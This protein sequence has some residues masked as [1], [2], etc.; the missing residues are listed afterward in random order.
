MNHIILCL[1]AT[2]AILLYCVEH[3]NRAQYTFQTVGDMFDN[4]STPLPTCCKPGHQNKP[5][6]QPF[7]IWMDSSFVH[8]SD[9]FLGV[10]IHCKPTHV[11]VSPHRKHCL[12]S[13]RFLT[14]CLRWELCVPMGEELALR[15]SSMGMW[16]SLQKKSSHP[17]GSLCESQLQPTRSSVPHTMWCSPD[18]IRGLNHHCIVHVLNCCF[19]SMMSCY[20]SAALPLPNFHH[21]LNMSSISPIDNCYNVVLVTMCSLPPFRS[22][23]AA[24]MEAP[25]CRA[26]HCDWLWDMHFEANTHK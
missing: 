12:L 21:P 16:S 15:I 3:S 14:N 22:Q 20:W 4:H 26:M 2:N 24:N 8:S 10:H 19:E 6:P 18:T 25:R 9:S 23:M 5:T 7:E 11:Y 13:E 1:Q 17:S